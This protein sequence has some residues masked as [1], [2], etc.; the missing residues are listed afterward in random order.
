[1]TAVF[2]LPLVLMFFRL[3]VLI[4]KFSLLPV[5]GMVAGVAVAISVAIVIAGTSEASIATVEVTERYTPVGDESGSTIGYR[6]VVTMAGS[7]PAGEVLLSGVQ[8]TSVG[9]SGPPCTS[10][11]EAPPPPLEF[12]IEPGRSLDRRTVTY[13]IEFAEPATYVEM[14]LAAGSEVQL[15][16][17][18]LPANV[19][20]GEEAE[21]ITFS[22]GPF[23]P[24]RWSGTI[25]LRNVPP[26]TPVTAV[27]RAE[28]PGD[29]GLVTYTGPAETFILGDYTREWTA[30]SR[31][32]L[33]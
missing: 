17:T 20:P 6:G 29:P 8:E 23:P 3:D 21:R 13:S 19:Q 2:L 5:V 15:Y 32:V 24:P 25:T 7:I 1:M 27:L 9:C 22:P 16:A 31:G 11:V 18:D 4:R 30:R 28:F 14:E 12:H 33:P 10:P 26:D